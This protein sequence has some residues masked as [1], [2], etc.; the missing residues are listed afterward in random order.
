MFFLRRGLGIENV[1]MVLKTNSI[2][3]QVMPWCLMHRWRPVYFIDCE[4]YMIKECGVIVELGA[5]LTKNLQA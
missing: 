5:V 4:K 2:L 3:S 1:P